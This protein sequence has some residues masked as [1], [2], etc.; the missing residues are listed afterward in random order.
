VEAVIAYAQTMT[1]KG[2]HPTV[3]LVTKTYKT[4][5]KLM[6]HAMT[7]LETQLQRLPRLEKWFVDIYPPPNTW[8]T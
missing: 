5:V 1:W 2:L 3:E 7:Q 6:K 8:D 4:G